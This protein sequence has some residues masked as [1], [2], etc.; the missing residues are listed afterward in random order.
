MSSVPLRVSLLSLVSVVALACGGGGNEKT[1]TQGNP[2]GYNPNGFGNGNTTTSSAMQPDGTLKLVG[3]I[4]DFKATYPDMEPCTNN[5]NKTCDSKH[6]EQH[7]G[8]ESTNECIVATT[9]GSDG[10]PQYAGPSGGTLTTTGAANFNNWFRDTTNSM[11][12]Q[13]PLTLTPDAN[14]VFT[15]KNLEFFPIDGKLFGNDGSDGNGTSHNFHFTTEWH[16]KFT[17]QPNQTFSFHGDDDLWVFID[18]QLQIDLGGIHGGQDATLQLDTLGFAPGS[19]H[20]FDIFYC[21]RHVVQS[22]IEIQTSIEFSGSV[23][24]N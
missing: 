1:K 8:C 21:E 23:L 11:S 10:K 4:R 19:D 13:L 15:Y 3:V 6:N 9:L 18:G 14:G 5:T 24:V 20:S 22:E 17:Y 16:L 2:S 7:P 12:D